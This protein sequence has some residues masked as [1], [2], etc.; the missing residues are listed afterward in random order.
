MAK[1]GFIS[2]GCSK[3]LV[4][5]EVMIGLLQKQGHT[6]TPHSEEAEILVVNTCSF[7]EA[8]RKESIETI[9]EAAR[10]KDSGNC[11][12][13]VVAGCLAERYAGEIQK[14]LSEVDAI[15][16]V[17]QI[18][19]IV[20]VIAGEQVAVPGSYGHSDADL[21]LYDHATPRTLI[22][23]KYSAYM[24]ISEGCDH[25][26]SFCAIPKI[27]GPFRSRTIPSLVKEA[28]ALASKGVKELILIS[29]DTTSYGMD[30][31]MEDGLA[32]LLE[33]LRDVEP[34]EWIRVLYVYPNLFS[35]RLI[36]AF[37]SS[38]KICRYVDMPLQHA[39]KRVLKSMKRGGTRKSLGR[40]IKHIRKEI[41][42]VT[43]RTT[44]IVGFPGETEDDFMELKDF[45]REME[46]DRLGVFTYSDEED[47]KAFVLP[48]KIPS[49]TAEK[50]RRILMKQQES[51]SVQKNRKL[52]GK[53]M[54][55]LVE[56]LSRESEFLL[57]GRLESQAPEIDGICLINDSEIEDVNSGQFHLVEITKVL[58]HDLMGRILKRCE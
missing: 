51:I 16:G 37:N 54:P 47:T 44:M 57:E 19:D 20:R 33:A 52:I 21:Y 5:S 42:G 24:K 15:V 43:F 26:C 40:L 2:L 49:R 50:R 48:S 38:Q 1:I 6:I 3:N 46:F 35:D 29:Q 8:S 13:L 14:D 22:G 10:L 25:V 41:P 30:L 27:R 12:K 53:R 7:I 45:C 23:P 18:E 31:G 56:G 39:S 28:S 55:V 4:D 34:L 11:K 9:L 17:N 36:D 58:G 32:S